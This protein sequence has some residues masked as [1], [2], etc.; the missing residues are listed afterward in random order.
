MAICVI[1]QFVTRYILNDSLAWTEE[2]AIYALI[3]VA[4]YAMSGPSRGSEGDKT[5]PAAVAEDDG[6]AALEAQL[7]K[8]DQL[9]EEGKPG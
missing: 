6:K 8:I 3:G 9:I 2:I 5:D 1:L 4:F 7:D